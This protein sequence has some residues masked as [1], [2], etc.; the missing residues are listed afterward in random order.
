MGT[1]QSGTAAAMKKEVADR[2]TNALITK[3]VP[4][5]V[6]AER[7]DMSIKQVR[8]SLKG[9]RSLTVEEFHQIADA[10]EVS[11]SSLLPSR[12]ASRDAA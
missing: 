8:A 3:N 5:T 11:P 2:I 10:I 1:P 7:T 9:H 6:L 12:F 4:A